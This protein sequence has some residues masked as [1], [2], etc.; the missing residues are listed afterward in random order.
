MTAGEKGGMSPASWSLYVISDTGSLKGRSHEFVAREALHGG[1][2]AIQ[3]RDKY[4]SPRSLLA[5]ALN[6]RKVTRKWEKPL[7][8]NDRIDIALA[9]RAEG[10][11]IGFDDFEYAMARE[12]LPP[13]LILGVSA[14]TKEEL[15]EAVEGKPDYIGVG[16]V[17][18][19]RETKADAGEPV[20]LGLL[21]VA[22]S[23]TDIPL[24]AIG[25]I[26]YGNASSV[27]RAGARGIA[28]I[29]SVVGADDISQSAMRLKEC[30]EEARA[31]YI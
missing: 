4:S 21:E 11:H 31:K 12:L 14:G 18:E 30:V 20:G 23:M 15:R 1:A 8:I 3:L 24:I 6:V 7:I 22:R 29:S 2:D 16:P 19:A 5:Q 27:I 17:F 9:A 28:V 13:P 10:A 25:G 26:H